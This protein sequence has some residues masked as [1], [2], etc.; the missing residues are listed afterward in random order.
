MHRKTLIFINTSIWISRLSVQK[1]VTEPRFGACQCKTTWYRPKYIIATSL[2]TFLPPFWAF[3]NTPS[4][5][6]R[7]SHPKTLTHCFLNCLRC[8][9]TSAQ[10]ILHKSEKMVVGGCQIRAIGGCWRTSHP[11]LKVTQQMG[12]STTVLS[13]VCCSRFAYKKLLLM[14]FG[15]THVLFLGLTIFTGHEGP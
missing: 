2:Y 15:M 14:T 5:K 9:I 12:P 13:F 6:F 1:L 11:T 10:L 8:L 3:E 4:V 7:S